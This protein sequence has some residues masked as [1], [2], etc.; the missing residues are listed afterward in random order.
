MSAAAPFDS[1]TGDVPTSGPWAEAVM[2]PIFAEGDRY[3]HYFVLGH[4]GIGLALAPFYD[5]WLMA[6]VNASGS[7][8]LVSGTGWSIA[9]NASPVS[10]GTTAA[11]AAF[12]TAPATMMSMIHQCG[13]TCDQTQRTAL[14]RSVVCAR[15]I[16]NST[17]AVT[18]IE[19]DSTTC[20][21]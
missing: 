11:R 9:L 16:E 2:E 14:E 21:W 20:L 15:C 4:F 6:I 10:T 8:T 7:S 3:S 5:T 19:I 13:R 12:P 17:G 1:E 18:D